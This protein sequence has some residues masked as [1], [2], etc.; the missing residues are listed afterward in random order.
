[1]LEIILLL[2]VGAGLGVVGGHL[3]PAL[4]KDIDQELESIK[5][6]AEQAGSRLEARIEDSLKPKNKTVI[7]T[8]AVPSTPVST[9][10]VSTPTQGSTGPTTGSSD[11]PKA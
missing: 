9:V 10:S 7:V 4:V 1:M 3:I 5:T 8:V 2:V 6:S 11:A